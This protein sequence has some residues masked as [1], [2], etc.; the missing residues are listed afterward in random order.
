MH[1]P[2]YREA[3]K[4]A[5][6]L[7]W[8]N[9]I[10]WVFG[11]LSLFLGQLGLGDFAG[12]LSAQMEGRSWFLG[13]S[14]F[15][16]GDFKTALG[17]IWIAGI[18]IGLG[19]LLLI[20]AI[21][22]QGA[23]LSAA[24]EG[25][26]GKKLSSGAV[27]WGRGIK[28]FW[29]L[30]VINCSRRIL[31]LALLFGAGMLWLPLLASFTTPRAILAAVVLGLEILLAVIISSVSIYA[32]G[33]VEIDN[34]G[35][36]KAIKKSWALFSRHLLVSLELSL[37]LL[38]FNILLIVAALALSTVLL[39]PALLIWLIVGFTGYG[40]LLGIGSMVNLVC[41]LI[42]L[43]FIG[44]IFNAFSTNAWVFLFMKMHKEGVGSRLFHY[45][46]KLF[47]R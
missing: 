3:I 7:T 35:I 1:E 20:A 2:T 31:L 40:G 16:I 46:G 9:K 42:F 28:H 30:L 38:C 13:L 26:K 41:L 44:A 37:F 27:L 36:F 23:L 25:F 18:L 19:I 29:P 21:I 10:L 22:S 12:H 34:A 5:W 11:L 32:L 17:V 43:A 15:H 47:K 8:N 33:Y 4:Q 14:A 45:F 6:R 24:G 39:L